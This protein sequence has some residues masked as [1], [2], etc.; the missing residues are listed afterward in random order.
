MKNDQELIEIIETIKNY[1]SKLKVLGIEDFQV[2][3]N[4]KYFII[5]T[6]GQKF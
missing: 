2:Y 4:L 5:G 1:R 6:L 3:L